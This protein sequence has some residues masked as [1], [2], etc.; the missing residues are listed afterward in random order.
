M[1]DPSNRNQAHL[2]HGRSTSRVLAPPGGHSTFSIG[3]YGGAPDYSASNRS[4]TRA[5]APREEESH[6][7]YSD[8]PR[9]YQPRDNIRGGI[10]GL[11]NHYSGDRGGGNDR[12]TG[13]DRGGSND[14]SA[15]GDR[16]G[17]GSGSGYR[18]DSNDDGSDDNDSGSDS[19][20]Q[21]YDEEDNN[22]QGRNSAPR[23]SS[24]NDYSNQQSMRNMSYAGGD[25]RQVEGRSDSTGGGG[26][27]SGTSHA[28][29]NVRSLADS[30]HDSAMQAYSSRQE[31]DREK[32]YRRMQNMEDKNY[33]RN[34]QRA[35]N[36]SSNGTSSNYKTT[37][38]NASGSAPVHTSTRVH[39]PPGGH[40][41]FQIGWS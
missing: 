21:S 5:P 10:P 18:R 26:R 30:R 35:N 14:R 38:A 25:R 31:S 40:S 29:R 27:G 8:P 3:G 9:S 17:G 23:D 37:S 34:A 12:S 16:G 39:A 24:R 20:R 4:K 1:G 33:E 41:S 13:G 19:R 11:E 32:D 15:G 7:R 6:Q 22:Q 36:S 28:S 2:T